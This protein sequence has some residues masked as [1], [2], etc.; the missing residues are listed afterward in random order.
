MDVLGVLNLG[1]VGVYFSK[2]AMFPVFDLA[3]YIVSILY[4]KYEPGSVEVSRK[5]PVAS[6]L[7]A[8]LYCFGSY[9]LADIIL[10]VCPIDYFHNNSHILLAT[11]VWYLIFYCPLNLFYK[12]VAFL[13]IKLVLV[14][15]KEVV[16]ARKIAAGVH[17][18]HH[19]YHH[20]YIIMIITGYVKGSGV[21]LMSN[22]EQLLRGVWK[23]ETNEIL[24]MSFPTKASLYGA[25]LFTLQEAHLLPVSKSTLICVFT[26][27]MATSKVFMT[28]RHS[29]GSP[30]ALV[31]SW[32]CHLL[33]GSPL[34]SADD[35]HAPAATP[36]SPVK[37]KEELSEG[38]RKRKA[39]KAE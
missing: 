29:H 38:T 19:A 33:F 30:F 32:V 39:K 22:F 24:N 37:T 10:G 7:C 23:P 21:A 14:A 3:Y 8:M 26:L 36:V 34:A 1:E 25:I 35:H 5:S 16:R 12:C 11:A 28:A 27:F 2:M 31:E 4:L 6:W 15:L 13:P 17:H 9:I 20:G 18:A